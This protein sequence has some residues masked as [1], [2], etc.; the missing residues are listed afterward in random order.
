MS[1]EVVVV[2]EMRVLVLVVGE[3]AVGTLGGEAGI[4]L[5]V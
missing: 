5:Q 3:D 4:P 2:G 1:G